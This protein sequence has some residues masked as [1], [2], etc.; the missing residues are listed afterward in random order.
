VTAA[1]RKVAFLV[2]GVQKGG[3]TAL[4]DYLSD[5]PALQ[6]PA[7]KE[8]HFFDDETQ[9]DWSAP[10][11]APYHGLFADDGRL[12][13]EATPIYLYWPNALER[14]ARYNPAMRL[15]LIFRDPVQ[16][17]WSHWKM[18]YAR[19]KETEPFAW[20]IR[21]G[22]A[23]MAEG[24]PYPGFHRVFS[25]V[26]RGFYGRQLA[27]ALALFPREQILILSSDRLQRDPDAVLADIA[28]FLGV[29]GPAGAVVPR[30]SRPAATIDYPS[31]LT[32]T[33]VAYL[34]RQFGAETMRFDALS[35]IPPL[36]G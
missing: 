26:V 20:C 35:G 9:V 17:A 24:S 19:G 33:D 23:R 5:L 32:A 10:D 14:I 30:V 12:W 34:Q 21:A 7:V 15:I 3:T 2:A 27:R 8:A 4:F 6:L 22:R 31:A 13:G 16:R 29:P 36:A 11:Y 25:Y 18:E 28:G 1:A